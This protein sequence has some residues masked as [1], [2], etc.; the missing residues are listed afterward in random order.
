MFCDE[1]ND[2]GALDLVRPRKDEEKE[3]EG[4]RGSKGRFSQG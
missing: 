3:E 1:S 2:V 4:R